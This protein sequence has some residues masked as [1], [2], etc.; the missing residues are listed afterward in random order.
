MRHPCFEAALI[1][2]DVVDVIAAD[3][4][5]AGERSDAEESAFHGQA[6]DALPQCTNLGCQYRRAENDGQYGAG[7]LLRW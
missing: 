1:G 7:C 4:A 3:R 2:V 6:D 5:F